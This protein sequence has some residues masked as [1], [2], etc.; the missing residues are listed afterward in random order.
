[1]RQTFRRL[2][3]TVL[4][5]L[6]VLFLST[7]LL[8]FCIYVVPFLFH[9]V[10]IDSRPSP[11]AIFGIRFIVIYVYRN[12]ITWYIDHAVSLFVI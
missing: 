8:N 1:M 11:L 7:S 9:L 6:Y 2:L 12:N 4:Q 10:C 5:I 3:N